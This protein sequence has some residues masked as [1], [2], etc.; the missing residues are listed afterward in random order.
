MVGDSGPILSSVHTMWDLIL[1]LPSWF[2]CVVS[3]LFFMRSEKYLPAWLSC[4]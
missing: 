2:E 4:S 1:A 3:M